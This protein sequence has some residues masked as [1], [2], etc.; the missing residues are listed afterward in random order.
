MIRVRVKV[1]ETNSSTSHTLTVYTASEYDKF[2]N[3]QLFMKKNCDQTL[4]PRQEAE[5]IL[6]DNIGKYVKELKD[7]DKSKL[8]KNCPKTYEKMIDFIYDDLDVDFCAITNVPLSSDR[9]YEKNECLESDTERMVLD[10]KAY[11]F[12]CLYGRDC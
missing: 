9:Y 10:G 12:Q 8:W 1:F 7:K 5:N 3:G 4:I 6:S 2:Q 11:V